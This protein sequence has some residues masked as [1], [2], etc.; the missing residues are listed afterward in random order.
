[1]NQWRSYNR[2]KA[3]LPGSWGIGRG[4]AG[5]LASPEFP[6]LTNCTIK[7]CSV[8]SLPGSADNHSPN[9]IPSAP[10]YLPW[11]STPHPTAA[12]R[13]APGPCQPDSQQL[14]DQFP[15][16]NL[17]TLPYKENLIMAPVLQRAVRKRRWV[18]LIFIPRA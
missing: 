15:I 9:T 6:I 11:P 10:S 3:W 5:S 18:S 8:L 17:N 12:P 13:P 4:G 2:E 1:M 16:S 7:G 14:P